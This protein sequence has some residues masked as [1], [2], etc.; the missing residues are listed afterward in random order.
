MKSVIVLV[1]AA[2]LCRTLALPDGAPLQ[3]CENLTPS[4][5]SGTP[6]PGR[7]SNTVNIDDFV[8]VNDSTI[9]YVYVPGA[10]YF[11]KKNYLCALY[12]TI[13]VPFV[14]VSLTSTGTFRGFLIQ[15]RTLSG[16][17][18]GQFVIGGDAT[19]IQ[20]SN[21]QPSNVSYCPAA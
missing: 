14:S 20:L 17:P 19:N 8:A 5:H 11:R 1:F 4:G 16:D 15:A 21:C 7:S 18:V 10:T 12:N 6:R 3:A 9:D 2:S 13:T